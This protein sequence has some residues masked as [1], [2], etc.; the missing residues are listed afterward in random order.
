MAFTASIVT[1]F[2]IAPEHYEAIFVHKISLRSV[3]KYGKYVNK[4]RYDL[5]FDCF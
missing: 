4:F 5:K 1:K 3:E 2:I